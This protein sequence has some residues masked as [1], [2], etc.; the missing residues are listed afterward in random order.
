MLCDGVIRCRIGIRQNHLLFFFNIESKNQT[1]CTSRP[2]KRGKC[3]IITTIGVGTSRVTG[4]TRLQYYHATNLVYTVSY[5]RKL[6]DVKSFAKDVRSSSFFVCLFCLAGNY[7]GLDPL[8]SHRRLTAYL[9]SRQGH[10]KTKK[11]PASDDGQ[12]S[13]SGS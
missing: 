12:W 4:K 2:S 3:A 11:T 7:T 13:T 9:V 5:T 1:K 10:P 6:N 8:L